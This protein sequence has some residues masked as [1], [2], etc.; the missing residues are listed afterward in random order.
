MSKEK[1]FLQLK[2]PK[3]EDL[4]SIRGLYDIRISDDY[5]HLPKLIK[6]LSQKSIKAT[7]RFKRGQI[8]F[9]VIEVEK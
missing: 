9:D 7:L 4:R 5:P 8:S 1:E 2:T 6:L 3:L